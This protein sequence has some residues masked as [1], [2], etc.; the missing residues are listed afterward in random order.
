MSKSLIQDDKKGEIILLTKLS[1]DFAN[2]YLSENYSDIIFVVD[3]EKIHCKLNSTHLKILSKKL[4]RY[5]LLNFVG[6]KVILAARSEYFRAL[7][8]GGLSE[9]NKKEV[10][11]KVPR[12]AFKI[13]LKY[14]YTG[15]IN[16]RTM[17]TPQMNLILDTL[18][19]S[20]LFGY[21][22]LKVCERLK[23]LLEILFILI[24]S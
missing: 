24:S 14:I 11:L 7:L 21:V 20:N 6:H 22:E 8:Y 17:L 2:L 23:F 3:S 4:Q 16:L 12:E 9:T 13:I 10:T 5:Q 19:L 1:E 15:K 18:G